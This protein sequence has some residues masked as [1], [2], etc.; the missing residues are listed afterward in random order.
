[1]ALTTTVRGP[2]RTH[3]AV[4]A[5][6]NRLERTTTVTLGGGGLDA[7]VDRV[8]NCPDEVA[9]EVMAEAVRGLEALGGTSLGDTTSDAR[10]L[11]QRRFGRALGRSGWTGG[12]A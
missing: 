1:M 6:A 3:E 7:L 9:Q 11:L 12:G 2:G 8:L 4:R 5:E 10:V